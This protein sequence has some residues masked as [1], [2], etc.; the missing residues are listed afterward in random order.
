MKI[1]LIDDERSFADGRE[2]TVI[3]RSD[4]AIEH[5]T[6]EDGN[7]NG[8]A[9]DE[10]WLD[11]VLVGSGSG[12]DVAMF[13]SRMAHRGTPLNVGMFK[14]H[15]SSWGGAA[16]M[17]QVLEAAGYKTQRVDIAMTKDFRKE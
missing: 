11:F 8:V 13:A 3:T 10:V 9:Y 7:Y 14:I 2:A 15:T 4:D 6:D 17:Q 16:L 12:G 5:F 1:L